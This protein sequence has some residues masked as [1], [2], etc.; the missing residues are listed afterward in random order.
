M[1]ECGGFEVAGL[2]DANQ[3]RLKGPSDETII[4]D[5][6][7][8]VLGNGLV[9]HPISTVVAVPASCTSGSSSQLG[10]EPSCSCCFYVC[11]SVAPVLLCAVH[12]LSCYGVLHVGCTTADCLLNF[13]P[14]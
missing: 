3:V 9:V 8:E 6:R 14:L 13:S 7:D 5:R 2:I 12:S 10:A 11:L 4:I 1:S